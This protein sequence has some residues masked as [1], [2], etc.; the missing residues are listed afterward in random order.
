MK[1]LLV[2]FAA[3]ALSASAADVTG[4][5]KASIETPNGVMENT[6][7]FKAEGN[8]LTGTLS[9]PMGERPISKGT[10]DGDNVSWTVAMEFNGNAFELNYKGKVAGNEMKITMEF[11]GGGGEGRTFEMIAKKVS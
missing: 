1:W 9:G 4:T 8:K 6:F 7:V 10:V 3:F 5:W 2:L 11:P